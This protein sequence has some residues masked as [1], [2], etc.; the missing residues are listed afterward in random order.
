MRVQNNIRVGKPD[1][2]T[3]TPTHVSGTREGNAVG[4]YGKAR[5]HLS[6]GHSTAERSTGINPDKRNPIDPRAPNLSPA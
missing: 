3:T 4:N 2:R 6:N 1:V 5:G